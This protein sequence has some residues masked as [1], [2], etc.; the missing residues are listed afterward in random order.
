MTTESKNSYATG[1]ASTK[2]VILLLAT[3]AVLIVAFSLF[4]IAAH[5]R[6]FGITN[7]GRVAIPFLIAYLVPSA[8]IN[9]KR[10]IHNIFPVGVGLW[11]ITIVVGPVLRAVFFGDTSAPA[12]LI[13]A[14][15]TLAVFLLGRRLI[16]KLITRH[17]AQTA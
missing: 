1:T 4:G 10:L 11:L 7:I 17:K 6:D 15:V 5:D 16:S 13:V 8:L 2:L 9:P 12:F 3:D 14:A